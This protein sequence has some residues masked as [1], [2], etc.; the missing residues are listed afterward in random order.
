MLFGQTSKQ[1]DSIIH[2]CASM[3]IQVEFYCGAHG[4]IDMNLLADEYEN[5]TL[6]DA[7]VFALL[8]GLHNNSLFKQQTQFSYSFVEWKITLQDWLIFVYFIKHNKTKNKSEVEQLWELGH[9]L[10][11]IPSLDRYYHFINSCETIQNPMHPEYDLMGLY[12]WIEFP[13]SCLFKNMSNYMH[14]WEMMPTYNNK[15]VMRQKT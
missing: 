6:K 14:T 11:G 7:N 12:R 15:L 4:C 13:N 3:A 5:G 9:K 2:T 8:F 1:I 10:G